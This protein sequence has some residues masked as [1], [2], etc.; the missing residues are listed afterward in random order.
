MGTGMSIQPSNTAIWAI[1]PINRTITSRCTGGRG[2][3]MANAMYK[4]TLKAN[5]ATTIPTSIEG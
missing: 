2:R 3:A 1:V 5:I 4:P